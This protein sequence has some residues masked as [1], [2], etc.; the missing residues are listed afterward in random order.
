MFN[1]SVDL[2]FWTNRG[3]ELFELHPDKFSAS[4]LNGNEHICDVDFSLRGNT[5]FAPLPTHYQFFPSH[6]LKLDGIKID[7]VILDTRI[8]IDIQAGQTTAVDGG[9]E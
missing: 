9:E 5:Y 6:I 3:Q 1:N 7:D 4:V 8:P 2:R